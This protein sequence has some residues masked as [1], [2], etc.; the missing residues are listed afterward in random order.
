MYR[1]CGLSAVALFSIS[2]AGCVDEAP[3]KSP[4][5]A[6]DH[7]HDHG[8]EHGGH[9]HPESLAEAFSELTELRD[10]V[11]E[12][13][14][15]NDT[16]AAHGPLHDV[17]H[18]L[19][20]LGEL[21][22]AADLSDEAKKQIKTQVDTLF[23]SFGAVDKKMHDDEGGKDYS[24]VSDAID[25][26]LKAIAEAAGPL[27][28]TH[29]HAEGHHEG[30]DHDHHADDH[31]EHKDADHDHAE[32]TETGGHSDEDHKHEADADTDKE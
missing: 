4:V 10:T 3:P 16:E 27:A 21:A 28:T 19:E 6:S 2:V 5:V 15:N 12:A 9:D 7:D 11:K 26:A 14:A 8:H 1:I 30:D 24:D 25:N 32:H 23:D 18:L 13:F 22:E 20:E 29:D 31:A 17:G